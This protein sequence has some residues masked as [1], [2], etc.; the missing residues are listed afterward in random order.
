MK[1]LGLG[2]SDLA[3]ASVVGVVSGYF[4]W[5]PLFDQSEANLG[6]QKDQS[7]GALKEKAAEMQ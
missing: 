7:G 5:K 3:L 6:V 4:L 1:R 2:R